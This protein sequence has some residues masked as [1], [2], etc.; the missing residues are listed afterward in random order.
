VYSPPH[1]W[2]LSRAEARGTEIYRVL[3]ETKRVVGEDEFAEAAIATHPEVPQEGTKG[4]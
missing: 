1:P 2:P 4:Y 3:R